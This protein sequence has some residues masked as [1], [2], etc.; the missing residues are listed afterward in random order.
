MTFN[1]ELCVRVH[2]LQVTFTSA[3]EMQDFLI[4]A[5]PDSERWERTSIQVTEDT[6]VD[7]WHRDMVSCITSLYK[8]KRHGDGFFYESDRSGA[9]RSE[10]HGST[11][12]HEEEDAIRK[13]LGNDAYLAGV[14]LYADATVVTLKGRSVHPIYIALLNHP[15]KKKILT[16]ET[17]A[18]M[19]ELPHLEG[20]D[21]DKRRLL[22]LKLYHKAYDILFKGLRSMTEGHLIQGLDMQVR[23]VVAVLLD[24]IGDNPEV[25]SLCSLPS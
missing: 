2:C 8:D 18:Y 24:F 20:I 15:Y 16:I 10:P 7:F 19:P 21:D 12:W 23:R 25:C 1:V 17:L 3:Q 14:Q 13:R 9:A 4:A 5:L 6:K 11:V 22:K